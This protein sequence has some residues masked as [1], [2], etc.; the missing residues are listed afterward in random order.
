[1]SARKI[2]SCHVLWRELCQL[3]AQSSHVFD[4]QFLEQG[5]HDTPDQLRAQ[6]QAAIDATDGVANAGAAQAAATAGAT[7]ATGA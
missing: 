7:G 6:L 2:I 3:A 4:F 1:M 5:L